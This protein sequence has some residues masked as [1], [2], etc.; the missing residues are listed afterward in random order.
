MPITMAQLTGSYAIPIDEIVLARV[1]MSS[2]PHDLSLIYAA[3]DSAA[4]DGVRIP[5]QS[6][7]ELMRIMVSRAIDLGAIAHCMQRIAIPHGDYARLIRAAAS[8]YDI[9]ANAE[10][11][12]H[13]VCIADYLSTPPRSTDIRPHWTESPCAQI[14]RARGTGGHVLARSIFE[15]ISVDAAARDNSI[16]E[17]TSLLEY[18]ARTI[19]YTHIMY[20]VTGM[21]DFCSRDNVAP[22]D[23]ALAT[24]LPPALATPLPP[25]TGSWEMIGRVDW[26][27]IAQ[28]FSERVSDD[29][30]ETI[31]IM[32]Y[33]H[34]VELAAFGLHAR[35]DY[36]CD[37]FMKCV[38]ANGARSIDADA[39][40][41][42]RSR[43]ESIPRA[44]Y[45][46]AWS[47]C[48][49]EVRVDLGPRPPVMKELQDASRPVRFSPGVEVPLEPQDVCLDIS[50]S[51]AFPCASGDTTPRMSTMMRP[52]RAWSEFVPLPSDLRR[53]IDARS[54]VEMRTPS[55]TYSSTTHPVSREEI[56][57]TDSGDS[58]PRPE[59]HH[60][61]QWA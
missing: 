28:A 8:V 40:Q 25:D 56:E 55:A 18:S 59:E 34:S 2:T 53:N 57:L 30:R 41:Q 14:P 7:E 38:A 46:P 5:S 43:A 13:I 4:C 10:L 24:P 54:D 47:A 50:R 11:L 17:W 45:A 35:P 31:N 37:A 51:P 6:M 32:L 49:H 22:V 42:I 20:V 29:V 60:S 23:P 19:P 52:V 44:S 15:T 33:L 16:A 3:F 61:R 9:D 1:I 26:T 39:H 36:W 12:S 58:T 21:I 48:P 27:A